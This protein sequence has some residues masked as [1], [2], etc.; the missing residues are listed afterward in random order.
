MNT[1]YGIE[2]EA[3]FR[4]QEWQRAIEA[5]QRVAHARSGRVTSQRFRLPRLSLA[6]LRGLATPRLPATSPVA[7]RRAP[8]FSS[9]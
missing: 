1:W 2:T 5:E 7:P 3:E 9:K 8:A 4:R 6:R